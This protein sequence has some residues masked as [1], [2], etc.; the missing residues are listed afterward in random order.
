MTII[1]GRAIA[2]RATVLTSEMEGVTIPLRV[3][4]TIVPASVPL[5]AAVHSAETRPQGWMV[6]DRY[7]VRIS[8]RETYGIV[9]ATD[10]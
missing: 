5:W 4:G 9:L 2:K 1:P 3:G 8:E 7:R 6:M 10:Y